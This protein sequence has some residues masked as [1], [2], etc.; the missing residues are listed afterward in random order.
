M[1]YRRTTPAAGGRR[2]RR[3][4]SALRMRRTHVAAAT[5]AVG[6]FAFGSFAS[7]GMD[8][9]ASDDHRAAPSSAATESVA[10]VAAEAADL[11]VVVR[12]EEVELGHGSV[13][14]KDYDEYE[15]STKVVTEGQ[16]GSALVSYTVTLKDGVEVERDEAM[17]VVVAEPVDEVVAVGA[18]TKP[19]VPTTTNAGANRALGRELAAQRGWTGEQ[20]NCLNALFTKESNWRHNAQNPS[21]SAYGIPQSLPGSKMASVGS[22]WRTN[23]ATQITWGLNYISG[24]YGTPC[25]AWSHSQSRGWY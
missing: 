6:A 12:T 16:D 15:G 2:D 7:A 1:S 9:W 21:S 25:G 13:E 18:R 24:R 5:I 14:E 20:W 11:E 22:D 3:E 4:R 23:P 10:P 8:A 17:R 19:S